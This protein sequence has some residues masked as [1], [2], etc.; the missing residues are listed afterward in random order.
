MSWSLN[1]KQIPK[2]LFGKITGVF[3]LGNLL[4]QE[5]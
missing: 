4:A 3:L 1:E 2:R 5:I